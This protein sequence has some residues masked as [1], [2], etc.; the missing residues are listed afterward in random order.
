VFEASE[1]DKAHVDGYNLLARA[2]GPAFL[3]EHSSLTH[4]YYTRKLWDT[5]ISENAEVVSHGKRR[6]TLGP[7]ASP[8]HRGRARGFSCPPEPRGV[9]KQH[10]LPKLREG[11]S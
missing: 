10:A 11:E 5:A 3:G 9:K 4:R 8:W 7:A 2:R 1:D 6:G